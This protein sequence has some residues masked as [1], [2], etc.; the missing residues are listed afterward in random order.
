MRLSTNIKNGDEFFT[1]LNAFNIIKRK[2]FHKLPIQANYYPIPSMAY[3]EDSTTRLTILTGSPLGTS[4]LKEGQIEIMLD[5]RLNQDDNLGLGQAVLDNHPTKHVFRIVLEQKSP[6]CRVKFNN[7]SELLIALYFKA[8]VEGHPSGFPTLSA[9][10]ASQTLLNPLVRLL[11]TEDEDTI[12]Q[13]S[14]LSVESEFGVDFMVPSLRTGVTLK[15]RDHVGLVLHRQF[16]D[17]CFAD[18][19][20]LNQFPLSQ[21]WVICLFCLCTEKICVLGQYQCTFTD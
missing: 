12:S 13:A 4:S 10:V 21:G 3:I 9:Y 1:D 14:Y 5:R 6:S 18:S 17:V 7:Q 8:T 20:L 19:N 15:G 16:V 11:R 2:R